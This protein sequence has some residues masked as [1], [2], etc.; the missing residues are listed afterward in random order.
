MKRASVSCVF[1]VLSLGLFSGCGS[2]TQEL[3]EYRIKAQS[4]GELI[5]GQASACVSQ[6]KAYQAVWE[7]AKVSEMDFETAAAQ[8]L[9]P[10]TEQNKDTM[11]E[12]KAM[13]EDLL[14]EL[15]EPP[16]SYEETYKKL[17]ELYGIYVQLHDL[18]MDPLDDME[19]HMKS[20]NELADRMAAKT[21]ELDAAWMIK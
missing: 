10:E 4:L 11:V 17:E 20:V 2:R 14:E 16:S 13:I 15:R 5:S 1:I 21:R 18:A 19:K 9:G 3:Q 7:Y 6:S 8:I 12:H